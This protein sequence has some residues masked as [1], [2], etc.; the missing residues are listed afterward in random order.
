[1]QRPFKLSVI[2]GI[3]LIV[4]G[5]LVMVIGPSRSNELP[6]GFKSPVIAFEFATETEQVKYIFPEEDSSAR[7]DIMRKMTNSTHLDFLFLIL[8]GA[9]LFTFSITCVSLTG[10]R[11]YYLPALLSIIAPLFDVLENL[12]M[13]S[14]ME[15]LGTDSIV[16]ELRYLHI[17]TWVK[18]GTLAVIFILL[19]PFYRAAG[20]FGRFMSI[21]AVMPFVLGIFAFIKPGLLNELFSVSTVLMFLLMFILSF[22]YREKEY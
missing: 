3:P 18:W 22:I 6:G 8:Y 21:F 17:F 19:I 15:R 12:Q 7:N 1:M 4:I 13:L 10:N 14:I 5:M 2:I 20:T 11:F 9:F 16:S